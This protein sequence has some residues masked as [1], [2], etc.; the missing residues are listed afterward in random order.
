MKRLTVIHLVLCLSILF[1]SKTV[2]AY[3][4]LKDD[5]AGGNPKLDKKVYKVYIQDN[6]YKDDAKDAVNKWKDALAAKGVDLQ[7]QS[8]PPP[9][10]PVDLKKY[11]EEVEKFN[12]DPNANLA[13]YPEITK[14]NNKK[15]T[16]SIYFESK[17][18]ISKRGGG[19]ETGL[20]NN[21]WNFD[22]NGHADKIEVSDVFL[23]TDPP[24]G[25]DAIKKKNIFNIALH[26][27]GHVSGQDHYTPEQKTNGGKVM[28]EDAT[29]HDSKLDLG[30]EEKKGINSIYGV[31]PN[32]KIED[33]AENKESSLLPDFIRDSIPVEIQSVWV[34]TYDL[35]W[36]SGS[37]VNYFQ[38]QTNRAPVFFALGSQGL[39]DWLYKVPDGNENYLDFYADKNYLGNQVL[40][41]RLE[42]YT[43]AA[44]GEGWL[45]ASGDEHL[46]ATPVPEPT[47]LLLFSVGFFV[48]KRRSRIA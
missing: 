45:I 35:T 26:E 22:G 16:I 5:T 48:I 31:P 4:P 37:E 13:D 46:G 44:P 47:S 7:I 1:L 18:D 29:L 39:D 28:Q 6:G 32:T 19:A 30:D 38:V 12:K 20:T 8:G 33:K 14:Y 3:Q 27:M 40:S 41:G 23:P 15:C 17:A 11:N 10:T 42:F 21:N 36:L 25:S 9:E 34:Y 24:G 2:L 43:D